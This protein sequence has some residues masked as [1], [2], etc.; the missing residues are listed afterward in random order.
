[1][2][3]TRTSFCRLERGDDSSVVRS[4]SNIRPAP[5][6]RVGSDHD[7]R[8]GLV[9]Q[10]FAAYL[11]PGRAFGVSGA[12]VG[13]HGF[14]RVADLAQRGKAL[15]APAIVRGPTRHALR[16]RALFPYGGLSGVHWCFYRR[17]GP[18]REPNQR[19]CQT[20]SRFHS[21]G[22]LLDEIFQPR[23]KKLA[24]HCQLLASHAKLDKTPHTFDSGE[25]ETFELL[26]DTL[27]LRRLAGPPIAAEQ[28]HC[29]LASGLR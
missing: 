15:R 14:A 5:D 24:T 28:V 26:I 9:L 11:P 6:I 8:V 22:A 20:R 3:R 12:L 17:V 4:I 13:D 7:F 1:M 18:P 23:G 21:I 16:A 2:L 29:S 19:V 25:V 10:F 27:S